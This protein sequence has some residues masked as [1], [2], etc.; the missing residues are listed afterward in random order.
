MRF[1]FTGTIERVRPP[2]LSGPISTQERSVFFVFARACA[3]ANFNT[4][5]LRCA[6]PLEFISPVSISPKSMRVISAAPAA[7]WEAW[8]PS[9]RGA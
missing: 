6:S 4:L 3:D 5:F 8:F 1:S 9:K 2:T 7:S